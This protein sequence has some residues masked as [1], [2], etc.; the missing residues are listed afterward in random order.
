[1]EDYLQ[2]L[3]HTSLPVNVS[4]LQGLAAIRLAIKGYAP[5][6]FTEEE[7]AQGRAYVQQAIDC[8]LKG[9]STGLVYL[10]EVYTKTQELIE[11]LRPCKGRSLIYMPH[12][13]TRHPA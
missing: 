11:L 8:G 7:L 9:F 5:D 6:P 10:P 3:R 12:M 1:M 2:A 4:T 13:R